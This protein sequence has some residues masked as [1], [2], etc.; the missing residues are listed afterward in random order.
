MKKSYT[1]KDIMACLN[2]L[3]ER[4]D[5]TTLADQKVRTEIIDLVK[6][7]SKVTKLTQ[8]DLLSKLDF[9][10]KDL[11]IEALEY[12]LAE[13]RSIFWLKNFQ[14]TNITPLQARKKNQQPDFTAKYK[15]KSC[16]IEVFCS[17]RKHGQQCDSSLGVFVNF[18]PNF[19]GSK[20]GRDFN[21]AAQGK[22]AQLDSIP[23][24]IIKVLLCVV[25]AKVMVNLNTKNDWDKH[26]RLLYKRLSWRPNYYIGILTGAEVSGVLSDTI[27][28]K[29]D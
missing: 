27:F 13:L 15:G 24:A 3:C 1:K 4:T 20:F 9:K 5:D 6:N 17:T 16:A 26:V 12:F 18:D 25:N 22:K 7:G 14:F 11:R 8:S 2:N 23:S 19:N 10:P 21:T 28:P 29:L